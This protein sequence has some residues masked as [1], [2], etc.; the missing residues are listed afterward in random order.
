MKKEGKSKR[1][2][3]NKE[4]SSEIKKEKVTNDK[5]EQKGIS[6]FTNPLLSSYYLLKILQ[7]YLK[8][9]ISFLLKYWYL[10]IFFV[11]LAFGPRYIKGP[12]QEVYFSS[13]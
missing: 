12:H 1:P 3:K 9:G 10:C 2:S 7:K 8:S 13:Y 11:A 5:K 4:K 6:I